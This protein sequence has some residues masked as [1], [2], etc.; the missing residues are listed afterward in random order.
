M[1]LT[2]TTA[3]RPR[4]RHALMP[5]FVALLIAALHAL[6]GRDI[7]HASWLDA[8]HVDKVVHAAMF[9]VLAHAVLVGMGKSGLLSRWRWAATAGCLLYGVVLEGVQGAWCPGRTADPWD[10]LA[11]GIGVALA[12][13]TFRWIYRSWPGLA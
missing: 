5:A 12:W 10:A 7:A 3:K 13:V 1:M 4:L 6:P 2:K 9:A 8:V 11:D